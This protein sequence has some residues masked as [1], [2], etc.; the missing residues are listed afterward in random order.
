MTR[1]PKRRFRL[2]AIASS[3]REIRRTVSALMPGRNSNGL[4]PFDTGRCAGFL[5]DAKE[6]YARG[7]SNARP[8]C[9]TGALP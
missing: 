2:P 3:A 7:F 4:I 1:K 6:R 8:I 5:V 9:G